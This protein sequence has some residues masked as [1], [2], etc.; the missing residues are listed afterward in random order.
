MKHADL[1]NLAWA[2]QP[3]R[4]PQH[5]RSCP[6]CGRDNLVSRR[7]FLEVHNVPADGKGLFG[8]LVEGKRYC[9]GSGQQLPR[10]Q[11]RKVKKTWTEEERKERRRQHDQDDPE[12]RPAALGLH[13]G[14]A[15]QRAAYTIFERL[16]FG[17]WESDPKEELAHKLLACYEYLTE[18]YDRS[19]CTG[20]FLRGSAMPLDSY[21]RTRIN[22]YARECRK[23]LDAAARRLEVLPEL[24]R[25]RN[26]A[27]SRRTYEDDKRTAEESGLLHHF[28]K[29]RPAPQH[30]PRLWK[31]WK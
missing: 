29:E 6:A 25:L 23:Q 14:N 16:Y 12:G 27:R 28:F 20:G 4:A 18:R 3:V 17:T 19:V 31:E 30:D 24:E 8:S 7:G 2:E 22:Q 11:R 10:A 26:A 13:R 1:I 21:E 15:L 9:R 5:P